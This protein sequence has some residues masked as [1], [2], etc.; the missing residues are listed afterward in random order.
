MAIEPKTPRKRAAKKVSS[1][2]SESVETSD[3]PETKSATKLHALQR[4]L[5]LNQ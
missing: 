3:A 5:H 4:K 1:K 2:K